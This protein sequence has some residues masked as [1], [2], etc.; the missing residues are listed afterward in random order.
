MCI[1]SVGFILLFFGYQYSKD[2]PQGAYIEKIMFLFLIFCTMEILHAWSYIKSVEWQS[3]Y[4]IM[5]A[6]Q[7]ISVG[8][9]LLIGL[10][11][12]L[13]L[14]FITS[15]KGEFYEREIIENPQEVTRWRDALD[16]LVL[17]YFLT[18]KNVL[19]RLFAQ[20]RNST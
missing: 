10:V 5:D 19:G 11:F 18:R 2:P 16:D 17:E 1:L 13:R 9:L 14:K 15:P 12:T 7:V 6:G 8:I 4:E 3:F 20:R